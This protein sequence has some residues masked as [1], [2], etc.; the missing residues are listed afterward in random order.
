[1]RAGILTMSVLFV[2]VAAC[3]SPATSTTGPP[4]TPFPPPAPPIPPQATPELAQATPEPPQA[5]SAGGGGNGTSVSHLEVQGGKQTGTYDAAGDKSD[6]NMAATGSGATFIDVNKTQGLTG[7]TFTSGEGGASPSRFYFQALFGA[8]SL[9]QATLE[10][11]T[12]LPGTADGSGTAQLEDKGATIKWTIEGTTQDG[13][14]IKAS[15]ECG[16]VDRI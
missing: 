7:F 15:I 10:I 1:M 8:F 9:S 16:P 2:L 3:A 12:L 4:A 5:T 13:V 6:C 14:A 11:S